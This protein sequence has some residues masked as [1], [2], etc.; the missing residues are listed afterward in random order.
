MSTEL[1][2]HHQLPRLTE[3]LREGLERSF[4]QLRH[5]IQEV[6]ATLRAI[7]GPGGGA[8]QQAS[9]ALRLADGAIVFAEARAE[10]PAAALALAAQRA[11]RAAQGRTSSRNGHGA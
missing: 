7:R 11:R 2:A 10:H 1:R 9:V 8:Y 5:V 3:R 6:R 4:E